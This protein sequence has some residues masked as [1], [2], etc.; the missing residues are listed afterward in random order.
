MKADLHLHS[1]FSPRPS[2]WLLQK[3]GCRESYSEPRRLYEMA[4]AKGMTLF[5]LTD[6]N[7]L[8][9]CLEIA[10]REGVFLSEEVTTYFPKDK[11]KAHVL[12]FNINEKHHR[13]INEL[14]ENIH[15]LACYLSGNDIPH[16]LAHPFYPVNDRLTLDHFEQ[17][18][19]LFGVLELNG[20][21]GPVANNCLRLIAENLTPADIDYL[22][23]KHNIEPLGEEPWRKRLIGGSDDHAGLH[24][25]RRYTEA[26]GASSVDE[27][28]ESVRLGRGLALG[29]DSTPQLTALKIYSIAYQ[30]YR[31]KSALP[32]G[33]RHD[34]L[35]RF[36]DRVLTPGEAV[37]SERWPFIEAPWRA[38]KAMRGR[39]ATGDSLV[40]MLRRGAEERLRSEPALM[41]IVSQPAGDAC[42]NARRG[43]EKEC[44]DFIS[45]V[46]GGVLRRFADQCVH[47][48]LGANLFDLFSSFGSAGA[49]YSMLAPYFSAYARYG[50]E[51]QFSLQA[52]R[53]LTRARRAAQALRP[54][55]RLAFFSDVNCSEADCPAEWRDSPAAADR[56]G[57]DMTF[58]TCR[59]SSPQRPA[60]A[61]AGETSA[62]ARNFDPVGAF[63]LHDTEAS[64]LHYPP[65]LEMLDYCYERQFTRVVAATPGPMGWAALGIARALSLPVVAVYGPAGR[66]YVRGLTAE[67]DWEDPAWRLILWLYE[68]MEYVSV[69]SDADAHELIERGLSPDKVIVQS[70]A[71]ASSPAAD[72]ESDDAETEAAFEMAAATMVA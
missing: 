10:G 67:T 71:G 23:N 3:I 31:D 69:A 53:H 34:V 30:F 62:E 64:A 40:E 12:V 36:L 52:A 4:R 18:L 54:V 46:T 26:P 42:H 65:F 16:A 13:E 39:M 72:T 27:F 6:H 9:G 45:Q 32:M 51:N 2:H 68:Q 29:E 33:A 28:F 59:D 66:D 19:L 49:L 11:C 58:V 56:K 48:L 61:S 7:T 1:K 47:R 60:P 17:M 55:E 43:V 15:D 63:L 25:A 37:A 5:T 8:D 21:Q 57:M 14:R 38:M 20:D 24:I 35:V 70:H 22:A 44:F 50:K 41:G